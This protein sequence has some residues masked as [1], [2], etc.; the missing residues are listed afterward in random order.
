MFPD[1]LKQG[2][3]IRVVS[4]AES[5]SIIAEDQRKLA[6]QRLEQLDVRVSYSTYAEIND[7]SGLSESIEK[8]VADLHEAFNDE[9]VTMIL[10]T[11]GGFDSNQ[12][13]RYLDY[14]LIRQNPKI[15]CG[16]SDITIL[17]NAIYQKTGLVTYNG[18]HFSTFGMKKGIE[19]TW[20]HF[21]QMFTQTTPYFIEQADHWSDDRWFLDQENRQFYTNEG[22]AVINEGSAAG[23]TLGGNLCT[24]NLLH[25]TEFMPALDNTILFLED[26]E[27]T[28]P[29]TFDRDLQSL[30]HQPG[31]DQVKGL[32]IGRFQKKS[33]VSLDHIH[34]IIKSKQ[35]LSNIPV[36]AQASFGHTTP[37]FTF[38]IGGKAAIQASGQKASIQMIEY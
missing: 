5:L 13:L 6:I 37:Q 28:I 32:V 38:P 26:D 30:I 34:A 19:Y 7:D 25:G 14:E 16:F 33:N 2:D 23:R 8:R 1:K 15:F 3:E 22:Y 18:P 36:I 4:P 24:L 9:R 35:E 27:M 21:R 10:T 29:Q 20:D 11:I 17:S 31:F 12:L